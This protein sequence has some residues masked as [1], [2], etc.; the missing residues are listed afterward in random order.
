MPA[1][2]RSIS[3]I[4]PR[5]SSAQPPSTDRLT[6]FFER[7]SALIRDSDQPKLAS[8]ARVLRRNPDALLWVRGYTVGRGSEEYNKRLGN[9]RARAVASELMQLGISGERIIAGSR[10]GK[11]QFAGLQKIDRHRRRRAETALMN[12]TV[13]AMRA[14]P[15]LTEV[16]LRQQSTRASATT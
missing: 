2:K 1:K 7:G 15:I 10:A 14:P 4:S 3:S 5:R 16:W 11:R 8:L 6:F 13:A 9:K 12:D